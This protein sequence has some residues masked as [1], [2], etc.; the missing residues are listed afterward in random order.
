MN[1]EKAAR[2]F[3]KSFWG[4]LGACFLFLLIF[5]HPLGRRVVRTGDVDAVLDA[6]DA[7]V[8]VVEVLLS[9]ASE[10]HS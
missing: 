8:H 5:F 2:S 9:S 6:A 1:N 3:D 4:R 10:C 7:L